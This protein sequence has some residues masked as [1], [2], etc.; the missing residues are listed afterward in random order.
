MPGHFT[1]EYTLERLKRE[2]KRWLREL[3]ANDGEARARLGRAFP[4]APDAPTLRDV[5][6]AIARELGFPGWTALKHE[7]ETAAPA[8][9]S[10]ES[11]VNRFLD[12]AC[13][14]HHVRGKRDHVRARHTAMRLLERHPAI[15][16]DSIYTAVVC[17]DLPA[18]ERTRR[19]SR[20]RIDEEPRAEPV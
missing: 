11:L 1:P 19:A 13:P 20:A 2:A 3:R 14:D 4:N 7:L 9:G 17:G 8:P 12:N 16:H 5:Q 15:A 6:H 10:R 18:V